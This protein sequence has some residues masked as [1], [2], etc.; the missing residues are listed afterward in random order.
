MSGEKAAIPAD[1]HPVLLPIGNVCFQGAEFAGSILIL[2][3][4]ITFLSDAV[5]PL[6]Q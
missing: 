2:Q 5:I 4:C 1:F 6:G 3:G